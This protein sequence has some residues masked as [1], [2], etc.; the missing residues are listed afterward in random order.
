M[1]IRYSTKWYVTHST[2]LTHY[3]HF[4]EQAVY[5]AHNPSAWKLVADGIESSILNEIS[6]DDDNKRNAF[7]EMIR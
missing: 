6:N 2:K 5:S 4:V 3:F 1:P 7:N